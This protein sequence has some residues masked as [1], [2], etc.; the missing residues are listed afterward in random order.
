MSWLGTKQFEVVWRGRDPRI[1]VF[2]FEHQKTWMAG[3]RL[4]KPG[5]DDCCMVRYETNTG[6][7]CD[8]IFPGQPCA[9]AGVTTNLLK[10][11]FWIG[12]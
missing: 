6:F 10:L 9:F 1:Y 3:T 12:L 2:A 7:A 5:Q 4:V 8:Q 11:K